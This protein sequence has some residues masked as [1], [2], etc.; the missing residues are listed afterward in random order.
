MIYTWGAFGAVVVFFLF[1]CQGQQASKSKKLEHASKLAG[2]WILNAKITEGLEVQVNERLMKLTL[3]AGGTFRAHYRG[4]GNQAWIVAGQGGFS[5]DPPM[6]NLYWESGSVSAFLVSQTEPD[7]ILIHH[8]RNL[9]PLKDQEPDE[10]FVRQKIE[11]G[12]I[13]TPS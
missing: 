13:R 2:T 5:Y 9:A 11:K 4:D 6:L 12:P 10:I 3:N 8:G 7:Q 1:S